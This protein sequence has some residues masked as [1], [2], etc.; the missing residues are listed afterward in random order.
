[1]N[2]PVKTHFGD[3]SKRLRGTINGVSTIADNADNT[4]TACHQV[5]GGP[6][7]PDRQSLA[8][9]LARQ[10][11]RRTATRS[12]R[13]T[14]RFP[15]PLPHVPRAPRRE[16][17]RRRPQPP[18]PPHARQVGGRERQRPARRRR[19]RRRGGARGLQREQGRQP[20]VAIDGS[21]L[22]V[23]VKSS[24]NPG[25]FPTRGPTIPGTTGT[26]TALA[27]PTASASS[28]TSSLANNHSQIGDSVQPRGRD[29]CRRGPGAGSATSTARSRSARTWPTTPSGPCRASPATGSRPA[30]RR[31]PG[32]SPG[33]SGPPARPPG[34]RVHYANDDGRLPPHGTSRRSSQQIFGE[35]AS[36]LVVEQ[37]R[38][39]PR[40]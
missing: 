23:I 22:P 15:P 35:P 24:G 34:A 26:T 2:T 7:S 9:R 33:S 39:E 40:R 14:T 5:V 18:Q 11:R 27:R 12:G 25:T 29:T 3:T 38:R 13:R 8:G 30:R 37:Q 21:D 28:A 1:M 17:E 6:D 4:C 19:A 31:R 36:E 20:H 32:S 16:L 10:L